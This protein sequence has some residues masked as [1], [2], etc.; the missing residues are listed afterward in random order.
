MP[1]TFV[2]EIPIDLGGGV[3]QIVT[4]EL[5]ASNTALKRRVTARRGR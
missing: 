1:S 4:A 5:K 3:K 2:A